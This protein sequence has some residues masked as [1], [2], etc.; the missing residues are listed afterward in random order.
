MARALQLEL[1]TRPAWG[2]RRCVPSGPW[3][4]G[5]RKRIRPLPS[6]NPVVPART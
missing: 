1:P 4:R 2:G 6:P 3:F 5:W